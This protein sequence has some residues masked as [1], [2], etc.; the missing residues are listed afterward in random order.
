MSWLFIRL[1]P[2]NTQFD[3]SGTCSHNCYDAVGGPCSVGLVVATIGP[4]RKCPLN[5]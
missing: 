2:L 3:R 4:E 1:K 5:V